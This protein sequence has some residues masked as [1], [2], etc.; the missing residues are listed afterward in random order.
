V[1][2]GRDKEN[3]YKEVYHKGQELYLAGKPFLKWFW[4]R[5]LKLK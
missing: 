2:N 4:C 3:M 5:H 1:L